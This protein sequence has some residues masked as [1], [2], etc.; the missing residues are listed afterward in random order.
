MF[1][2][3]TSERAG[4][5]ALAETGYP[6]FA[7][8]SRFWGRSLFFHVFRVRFHRRALNDEFFVR[9]KILAGQKHRGFA[10]RQRARQDAIFPRNRAVRRMKRQPPDP[11]VVDA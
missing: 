11:R 1:V 2:F 3:Q 10:M 8:K 6:R 7:A 9:I 5:S 4:F